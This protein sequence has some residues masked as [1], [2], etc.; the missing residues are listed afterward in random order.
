MTLRIVQFL[1]VLFTALSL[2]PGGAHVLELPHKIR[3]DKDAYIAV[4][5]LYRGWA[6]LGAALILA[7]I[8]DAAAAF[9]MR[10]QSPAWWLTGG[11]AALMLATLVLF[12][13]FVFPVN[14]ATR[15]WTVAPADWQALRARWEYAHAVDAGLTLLALIAALA[16]TLSWPEGT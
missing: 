2:V 8:F 6:F 16:G 1:A 14:Q 4:Q 5:Q 7:M 12:F 13:W 10:G 9:M 3:L 11:A 15:N